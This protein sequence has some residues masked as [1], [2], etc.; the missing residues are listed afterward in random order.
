MYHA[1]DCVNTRTTDRVSRQVQVDYS[2][3]DCSQ[4]QNGVRQGCILS[5]GRLNVYREY[6]IN[7]GGEGDMVTGTGKVTWK[8][9]PQF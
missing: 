7:M 1:F 2:T 6:I 5:P 3:T 9:I 8:L 4:M